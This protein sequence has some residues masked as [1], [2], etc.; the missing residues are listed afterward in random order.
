MDYFKFPDLIFYGNELFLNVIVHDRLEFSIW[1]LKRSIDISEHI[2]SETSAEFTKRIL[3]KSR[4]DTGLKVD[5]N[6]IRSTSRRKRDALLG[7]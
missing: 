2:G 6:L 3:N 1:F 5:M 7:L 4:F